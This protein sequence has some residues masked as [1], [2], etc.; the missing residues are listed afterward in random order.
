MRERTFWMITIMLLIW[1][2]LFFVAANA[3]RSHAQCPMAQHAAH[4]HD[5]ATAE[6]DA[7]DEVGSAR[8]DVSYGPHNGRLIVIGFVGGFVNRDD[9]GHPEVQVAA[10][11]AAVIPPSFMSGCLEIITERQ[12]IAKCC[13]G[14]TQTGMGYSGRMRSSE[15]G[16]SSTGTAGELQKR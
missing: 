9:R 1:A 11:L 15:Q 6:P 13:N 5:L 10:E 14:S 2:A 12:L 8:A 16:S 4:N 7:K 3:M